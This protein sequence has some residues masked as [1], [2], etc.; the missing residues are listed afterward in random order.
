METGAAPAASEQRRG[1]GRRR[2]MTALVVLG[3]HLLG[4]ASSI[5]AVMN[6]RTEQ[7]AIAWAVSL[8]TLTDDDTSSCDRPALTAARSS[9]SCRCSQQRGATA[10]KE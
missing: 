9:P 1:K 4:I 3:F 5:H 6:T 10:R 7:G 2:G 8:N